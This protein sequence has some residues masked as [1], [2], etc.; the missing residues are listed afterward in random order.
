VTK[1]LETGGGGAGNEP[2]I[3]RMFL[4]QLGAARAKAV[5]DYMRDAPQTA[6]GCATAAG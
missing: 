4:T 1:P 3:Q 5:E 6:G 2:L